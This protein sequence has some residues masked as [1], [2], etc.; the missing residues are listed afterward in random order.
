MENKSVGDILKVVKKYVKS[1]VND[2]LPITVAIADPE[3]IIIGVS[4]QRD[5]PLTMIERSY[6]IPFG[7]FSND[8]S[9]LVSDPEELHACKWSIEVHEAVFQVDAINELFNQEGE[10][11]RGKRVVTALS[12]GIGNVLQNLRSVAYIGKDK[13][14]YK[15]D[16][17]QTAGHPYACL[18]AYS[19][20]KKIGIESLLFNEGGN[21]QQVIDESSSEKKIEQNF[22][23]QINWAISGYPLIL[24]KEGVS[25]ETIAMNSSD[26]R[27]IWRLPLLEESLMNH[28]EFLKGLLFIW[29][30]TKEIPKNHKKRLIQFLENNFGINLIERA[31]FENLNN[32]IKISNGEKS[33]S[34]KLNNDKTKVTIEIDDVRREGRTTELYVKQEQGKLYIYFKDEKKKKIEYFFGFQ[35]LQNSN[36]LVEAAQ[37]KAITLKYLRSENKKWIKGMCEVCNIDSDDFDNHKIF[38]KENKQLK[39]DP[40][41][42]RNDLMNSNYIEKGSEKEVIA[43]GDFFIDRERSEIII[44]LLPAIYPQHIVCIDQKGCVINIS[45]AGLGGRS[46]ITIKDAQDMCKELEFSDAIILDNGF[47]VIAR[48]GGGAVLCHKKNKRQTRL[49]A[50]LHFGYPLESDAFG[51]YIEGLEIAYGTINVQPNQNQRDNSKTSEDISESEMSGEVLN[52]KDLS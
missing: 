43:S 4:I 27:H 10:K 20:N 5:Y 17:E 25:L 41:E 7:R 14:L 1:Y 13:E 33:L 39:L 32:E 30:T 42:L 18:V 2:T 21:V 26:F 8:Q 36:C 52:R 38:D 47:D 48:I 6:G 11:S 29:D 23:S 40:T 35:D 3:K 46:G 49:T 31:K 28:L 19:K 22:E 50:S 15:V 45:I 16:G 9:R 37:D 44:K 24:D 12:T 34:L 51:S